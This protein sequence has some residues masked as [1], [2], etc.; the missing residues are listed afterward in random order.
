M[1]C[2]VC[3]FCNPGAIDRC[4]RCRFPCDRRQPEA[5][6]ENGQVSFDLPALADDT[7]TAPSVTLLADTRALPQLSPEM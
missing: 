6:G 2:P 5:A 4:L 1:T 7:G 3:R